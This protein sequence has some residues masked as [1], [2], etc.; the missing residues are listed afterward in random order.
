MY[1]MKTNA[2]FICLAMIFCIS[3]L[4]DEKIDT[5]LRIGIEFPENFQN[6]SRAGVEVKL[7]NTA[8]G[9]YYTSV[10]NAEGIASLNVEYGFYDA[11]VQYQLVEDYNTYIFN[12]RYS[13]IVLAPDLENFN[14]FYSLP[15]T[16]AL[17]SNLIIKE[18]YFG[19]CMTDDGITYHN[20]NY[21]SLYN[22]SAQVAYLDGICLGY[23]TPITSAAKSNFVKEDGTLM[24]QLPVAM[25]AWQIPG[26]GQ[27]YP[28]QPGEEVIIAVN[29]VNHKARHSQSVDLSHAKF[30]FYNINLSMQEAP[31]PGVISLDQIWKGPGEAYGLVP[32][33]GPAMILF[34]IPGDAV[35]YASDAS[36]L[37]QDPV[38]HTG[39][40]N[41]MI[42]K[43]WVLDG[44]ECIQSKSSVYKRLTDNIDAGFIC[45]ESRYSGLSVQRKVEKTEADG[46][47][48]YKDTNNSSE[49]TEVAQASLKNK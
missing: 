2:I 24:D 13:N 3:C 16:Y 38:T 26:N 6:I 9:R 49:D 37:M 18:L 34:K 44:I 20:D 11:I 19:G 45:Q 31:A 30:A 25:M 4:R 14:D 8:S 36:H 17:K 28:I 41:L 22:N 46:R 32:N 47:I 10:T 27:D 23:V 39:S 29:A 35:A 15:L 33:G 1:L 42:D 7:Y 48:V 40:Y 21:M 12:G 5:V 43:E